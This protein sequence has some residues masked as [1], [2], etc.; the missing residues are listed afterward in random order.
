MKTELIAN[1]I[2]IQD[3][4]IDILYNKK[5]E[6]SSAYTLFLKTHAD[7]IDEGVRYPVTTWKEKDNEIVYCM[8]DNR[9]V[10]F[11]N[12]AY[13]EDYHLAILDICFV[14]PE[15]RNKGIFKVLFQ[16]LE[17]I[18]K[19]KQAVVLRIDLP[20]KIDYLEKIFKNLGFSLLFYSLHKKVN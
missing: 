10:G 14:I 17:Q 8:I 3:I 7:L 13:F 20:I 15:Y 5:I 9:P 11:I 4:K 16:N 12:Y 19:D 2:E 1:A 6:H 18:L